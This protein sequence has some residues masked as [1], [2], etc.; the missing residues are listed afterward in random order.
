MF[1]CISLALW[2]FGPGCFL[3]SCG[4][5]L[6]CVLCMILDLKVGVLLLGVFYYFVVSCFLINFGFLLAFYLSCY[7]LVSL[8]VRFFVVVLVIWFTF[9]FGFGADLLFGCLCFDYG[10]VFWFCN[11]LIS[12]GVVICLWVGLLV[13]W[14][15]T[16]RILLG[17][18][19]LFVLCL[20]LVTSFD[21]FIC[22]NDCYYAVLFE[23]LLWEMVGFMLTCTCLCGLI[24]GVM[25]F[26]FTSC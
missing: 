6:L 14:F 21:A 8:V 20:C 22:N 25:C 2:F 12:F 15:V 16:C 10:R 13:F 4:L 3:N 7:L 26:E 19:L 1:S 24:A 11:G 9:R 17:V 23:L 5:Q 18:W